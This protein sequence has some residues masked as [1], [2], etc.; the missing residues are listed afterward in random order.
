[1]SGRF[2]VGSRFL[3]LAG[4]RHRVNHVFVLVRQVP[5]S[6]QFFFL[7]LGSGWP[8]KMCQCLL[9]SILVLLSGRFKAGSSFLGL[10]G[11]RKYQ[12]AK[13]VTKACQ[14]QMTIPFFL[15]RGA[16]F[17][18]RNISHQKIHLLLLGSLPGQ[19]A[20]CHYKVFVF[21]H[22]QEMHKQERT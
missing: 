11:D 15:V 5:L 17:K 20:F 13:G 12:Y 18:H 22:L 9:F 8:P 7:I 3:D 10:V 19:C 6:G 16:T 1:M 21:N 14:G 2:K 4:R